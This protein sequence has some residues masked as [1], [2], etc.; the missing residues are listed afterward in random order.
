MSGY[1]IS[2]RIKE[3]LAARKA[4]GLALGRPEAAKNTS[5]PLD[6]HKE[7]RY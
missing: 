7:R 4:K 2:Q 1:G 5:Y 3:A 6:K